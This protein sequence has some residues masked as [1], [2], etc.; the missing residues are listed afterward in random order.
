[1][2]LRRRPSRHAKG[3]HKYRS[4]LARL[5]TLN[6]IGPEGRRGES[7]PVPRP[8]STKEKGTSTKAGAKAP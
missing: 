5:G 2:T 1:M 8:M 3:C 4:P 6:E 7:I